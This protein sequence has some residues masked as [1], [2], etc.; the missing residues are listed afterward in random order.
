MRKRI[1]RR[2]FISQTGYGIGA[3]TLTGL[4]WSDNTIVKGL[5][6]RSAKK[7]MATTDYTDNIG[8]NHRGSRYGA[9]VPRPDEYY[10][11]YK[12]FMNKTQLDELHGVLASLGVTRHQ[13][14]TD[15]YW[16]LYENYPHGFNLLAEAVKSAH[17]YGIEFYAE[18]KPFEGGGFGTIL[19]HSMPLPEGTAAKDMRGIF[20]IVR[21]FV[22]V[23]PQFCLKRKPGTYEYEGPVTKIRLIKSDDKPTRVKS[24]HLSILTSPSNCGFS[25]YN[26]P[27]SFRESIEW[28]FQFP[29]W[30]Q[31]RVLHLENLILPESHKYILIKCALADEDA[32]FSNENG[33]ILELEGDRGKVI[34][35][36][37]STGPVSPESHYN[38]FYHSKILKDLLRYI[39]H[40]E[41]K[42]ETK[43]LQM[44]QKHYNNFYN[45]DSYKLTDRKTLDADG[46]IAAACGK[47]EYMLGNL[48]PVYP[49]VREY[50]LDLVR[51]CLDQGVDGINIRVANHTKLPDYWEYGF[52][53]PVIQASGGKTDYPTVSRINGEAYTQF[54]RE[55]R[56]L[57]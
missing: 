45:F 18:I 48:H 9:Q 29:N 16:T 34:P 3:A 40:P 32:D 6:E 46:Y 1:N 44:L 4:S 37:L 36:I 24:E 11:N 55:A 23:N 39:Q 2:T 43:T 20:P 35:H 12:C 5:H 25:P 14:I 27:V 15:T 57:I 22:A 28:R 17:A 31:C 30:E 56:D 19:P 21:P 54:L 50:W 8:I 41:V 49:E 42:S 10:A 51:F 53:E 38:S 52:N 7:L 13:W 33:K 47:P 26:G